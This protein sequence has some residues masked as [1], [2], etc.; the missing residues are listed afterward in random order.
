MNTIFWFTVGVGLAPAFPAGAMVITRRRAPEMWRAATQLGYI[1]QTVVW[2][3]AGEP[4]ALFGAITG[5]LLIL[6]SGRC[7]WW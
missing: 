4:A 2:V 7:R 1:G 5:L 3:V 6:A